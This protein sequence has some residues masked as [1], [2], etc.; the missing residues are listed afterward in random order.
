MLSMLFL[1]RGPRCGSLARFSGGRFQQQRLGG[2]VLSRSV[3]SSAPESQDAETKPPLLDRVVIKLNDSIK[4][5]P[6]ETLAVLF[7]SDIGSIGAMY[8]VLSVSGIEFSPE[9]ALAFAASR[10]FRRFRLPL[11]LAVAAGVSKVFPAFSKVRLSDLAGVLPNRPGPAKM[12]DSGMIAKAMNKAKDVIDNYGA[13]YMMG[14]RLA[15]VS[16]VCALYALIKQGMDLMPILASLGIDSVGEA[17]GSYAAAVVFSSLFYPATLGVSGYIVPVVAKLRR[18]VFT[19]SQGGDGLEVRF[20][21]AN[22]TRRDLASKGDIIDVSFKLILMR[23]E[24]GKHGEPKLCYYDLKLETTRLISLRLE[25]E[26]VHVINAS[27][28]LFE[29]TSDDVVRSDFVF[30]LIASG[31]DENLHDM[32][33]A[34]REYGHQETRWGAKFQ[35]MLNW[36]TK[37]KFIELDLD[38]ISAVVSAPIKSK[39]DHS[40]DVKLLKSPMQKEEEEEVSASWLSGDE[41]AD[42]GGDYSS[43]CS[44]QHFQTEDTLPHKLADGTL[45]ELSDDYDGEAIV[46]HTNK[47]QQSDGKVAD[48]SSSLDYDLEQEAACEKHERSNSRSVSWCHGHSHQLTGD[49]ED[50]PMSLLQRRVRVRNRSRSLL[51][52]GMYQRALSASWPSLLLSLIVAYMAVI[53]TVAL[54]ISVSIHEPLEQ[55]VHDEFTAK[56]Q[57]VLFFCV[58]TVST[59]G[60]GALSPRQDSNA[61]NFFVFLL[62]FSGLLVSTLLTGI[63]WAKFSIPKASTLL[64]SDVLLLTTFHSQRAIMFRAANNRKYG[65]LVE[66]SFRMSIVVLNRNFGRRE[67][68]ELRLARNVWPIIS[69]CNTVTHIIDERSPLYNLS[70]SD[71]LS[72]DHFFVVLFTGLDNIISDTMVARKAYHACDIL[73]DHH[74][75]DNITLAAD[76][77]YID[78]DAINATYCESDIGGQSNEEEEQ[79]NA[80]NTPHSD[81][82]RLSGSNG[83]F[84]MLRS[85]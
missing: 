77:L 44:S 36:D 76:G 28:P 47:S 65:V 39:E 56:Y 6:G 16:V 75:E 72:G 22:E 8:G 20:R 13:A 27:S 42:N 31:L 32:I 9:F 2:V 15:G 80:D 40:I 5:H 7:A 43:Q 55:R 84:N 71:L 11:D 14:S 69:L 50:R 29:Q 51:M 17:M 46:K 37:H 59:V 70:T 23:V 30:I 45:W 61:A 12:P 53:A 41:I 1:T 60:Y 33:H 74:F 21:V 78:L 68:H 85:T 19:V 64:Y 82:V 58:Q 81:Y 25:I 4:K 66:G 83:H 67:T 18:T 79:A 26:L 54:L 49:L 48:T 34:K 3:G 24:T 35:P 63:T 52:N 38:K 62:V 10:P 73:V 57:E